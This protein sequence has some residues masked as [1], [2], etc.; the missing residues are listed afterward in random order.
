MHNN[1][2]MI[3]HRRRGFEYEAMLYELLRRAKIQVPIP[4]HPVFKTHSFMVIYAE[5]SVDNIKS[6]KYKTNFDIGFEN[7]KD[8]NEEVEKYSYMWKKGGEF[9]KKN[10]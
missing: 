8:F 7:L 3:P 2:Q 5:N 9:S 10:K 4:I 1:D 6:G